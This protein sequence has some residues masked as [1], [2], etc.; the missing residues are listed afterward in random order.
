MLFPAEGFTER[1]PLEMLDAS[2]QAISCDCQDYIKQD[3]IKM[4]L[5]GKITT[6][7]TLAESWK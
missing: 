3:Y 1:N 5:A 2:Y 7:Y 4:R 6:E